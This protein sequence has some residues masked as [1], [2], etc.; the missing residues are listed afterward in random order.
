M[1][2]IWTLLIVG[3]ICKRIALYARH[4]QLCILQCEHAGIERSIDAD[5]CDAIRSKI[6]LML[7]TGVEFDNSLELGA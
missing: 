3:I 6:R 5:K 7:K 1:S 4:R 2:F